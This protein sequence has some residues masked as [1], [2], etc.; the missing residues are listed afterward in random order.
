MNLNP[1]F[2]LFRSEALEF[3]A[4]CG[5]FISECGKVKMLGFFT[6]ASHTVLE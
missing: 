4:D 3:D 5:D 6:M 2:S 1:L